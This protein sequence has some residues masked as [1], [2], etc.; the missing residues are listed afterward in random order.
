MLATW[1]LGLTID[2]SPRRTLI[3]CGSSSMEVRRRIAPTRVMRWLSR[4]VPCDPSSIGA[5]VIVRNLYI[6]RYKT[7][8]GPR[9]RVR[10]F[11]A[12]QAEAA[13]GVAVLNWML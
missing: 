3:N 10:G 11:A 8:I 6:I 1:G 12:Q 4:L 2:I 9:L 13:I 7:L 5:T